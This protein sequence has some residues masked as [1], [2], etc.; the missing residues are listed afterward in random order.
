MESRNLDREPAASDYAR[1][2][3]AA[4]AEAVELT[5][6]TE[7]ER[8]VTESAEVYADRI[9]RGEHLTRAARGRFSR[10]ELQEMA[11]QMRGLLQ[12][13]ATGWLPEREDVEQGQLFGEERLI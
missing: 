8:T 4:D 5:T 9:R 3:E 6:C 7:A 12:L 10:R 2:A 1:Q 13:G 11:R